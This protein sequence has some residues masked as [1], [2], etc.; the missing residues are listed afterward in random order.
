MPSPSKPT[1]PH[2][3]TFELRAG[4]GA[5]DKW[6]GVRFQGSNAMLRPGDLR[7]GQNIRP[8]G[9]GYRERGGLQKILVTPAGAKID[10]IFDFSDIGKP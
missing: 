9:D 4:I 1:D 6:R 8:S 7:Q 2:F 5:T 10:G 3:N